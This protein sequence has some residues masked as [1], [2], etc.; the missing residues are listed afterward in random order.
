MSKDDERGI[1]DLLAG[2]YS[3]L[4]HNN[5]HGLSGRIAGDKSAEK[6]A[7]LLKK[8]GKEL[9]RKGLMLDS[10]KVGRVNCN[11]VE[12]ITAEEL[13]VIV[14]KTEFVFVHNGKLIKKTE[15]NKKFTIRKDDGAWAI[16]V[17]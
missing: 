3:D 10:V 4:L 6:A 12:L 2:Y 9:E 16:V 14:K 11:K 1:A 7:S 5:A 15:K 8:A 13:I 17:E